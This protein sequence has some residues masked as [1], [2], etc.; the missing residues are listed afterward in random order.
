MEVQW[1]SSEPQAYLFNS[2]PLEKA[3]LP[4]VGSPL[5]P[6]RRH[7]PGLILILLPSSSLIIRRHTVHILG[8]LAVLD[9]VE[10]G[11]GV[12][13]AAAAIRAAGGRGG[14]GGGA[15]GAVGEEEGTAVAEEVGDEKDAW[16][17]HNLRKKD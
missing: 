9:G 11:L 1:T 10:W 4:V 8:P 16:K 13:A 6:P 7:M 12:G 5:N 3:T 14:A 15:G 17:K 2:R